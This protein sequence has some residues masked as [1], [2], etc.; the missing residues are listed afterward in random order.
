MFVESG[1]DPGRGHSNF[2]FGFRIRFTRT[3]G[4]KLKPFF[5]ARAAGTPAGVLAFLTPEPLATQIF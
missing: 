4:V 5:T 3:P 1:C 2:A